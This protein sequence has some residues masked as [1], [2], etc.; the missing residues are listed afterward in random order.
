MKQF[1]PVYFVALV[2]L[3]FLMCL[4]LGAAEEEVVR[5]Y[6]ADTGVV[7]L[8]MSDSSHDFVMCEGEE[9]EK[10]C[11][12][13]TAHKVNICLHTANKQKTSFEV[14]QEEEHGTIQFHF[15]RWHPKVIIIAIPKDSNPPPN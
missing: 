5:L 8:E 15:T 11:D 13:I 6:H 9:H 4:P 2:T 3:F 14:W 7:F 1:S 10:S 12:R